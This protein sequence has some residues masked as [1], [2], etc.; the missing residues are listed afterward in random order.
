LESFD[1]GDPPRNLLLKLNN[2]INQQSQPSSRDMD[3]DNQ[4]KEEFEKEQY[5]KYLELTLFLSHHK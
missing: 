2:S 1:S 4:E 3:K 5:I